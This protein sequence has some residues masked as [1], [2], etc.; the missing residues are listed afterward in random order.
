MTKILVA[1]SGGV[2]S[3]TT[4]AILQK[5]GY[6]IQGVTMDLGKFCH[7]TALKDAQ[8]VAKEL[9]I[10]HHVL[11]LEKVF[12]KEVVQYFAKSYLNGETPNPCARCN[13]FIKFN[14]LIK[15][16]KKLK[17]DYLATG[18]YAKITKN[19]E[20][21]KLQKGKDSFKDQSYFL[22]MI[23]PEYL[24]YIKFPLAN[25]EKTQTRKTAK[26]A[27]LSTAEKAESQD[28]CFVQNGD[29]Q[30]VIK[31]YYPK[32]EK[33]GKIIHINGKEL[34][35]HN[36]IIN[37]T[38]G[39]RKGLGIGYKEPLYVIEI[40]AKTNNV[41]VGSFKD[42]NGSIVNVKEVNFLTK[43]IEFNKEYELSVKLRFAHKS[44]KAK[45]VFYKEQTAE[46][47]LEKQGR[48]ITKGQVCAFYK[49]S[50]VIGGGWII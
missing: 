35:E 28:I 26:T 19:K 14:E 16:M 23:N 20:G 33:S 10:K 34:G 39:Q 32:C 7:S 2:D 30:K 44:Q 49:N 1:M 38:I 3:S 18:H 24:Q 11:N 46:V 4:A 9:N 47:V 27:N 45:V 5:Q 48:A 21:Y 41:I 31:Q 40:N 37:Y 6:E 25:I 17:C 15:F 13:K 42:L 50:Q 22:T 36:G 43:D 8:K 29:Y 12:E